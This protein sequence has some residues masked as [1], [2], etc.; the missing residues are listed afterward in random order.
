MD[1]RCVAAHRTTDGKIPSL[2]LHWQLF[3]AFLFLFLLFNFR[4]FLLTRVSVKGS[5]KEVYFSEMEKLKTYL[6]M[7][8]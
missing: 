7:D 2:I 3:P 4:T 8:A 1:C 5:L 6:K